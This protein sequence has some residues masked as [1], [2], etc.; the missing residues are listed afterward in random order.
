LVNKQI[1][2]NGM[3]TIEDRNQE[4]E[5]EKEKKESMMNMSE[6][7]WNSLIQILEE[8]DQIQVIKIINTR[9]FF[10]TQSTVLLK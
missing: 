10:E 2:L 8:V 3:T 1:Y 4:M 7:Y 6:F 9:M 5:Q